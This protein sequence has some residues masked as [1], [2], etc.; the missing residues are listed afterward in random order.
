M[1][2]ELQVIGEIRFA[3]TVGTNTYVVYLV[4]TVGSEDPLSIPEVPIDR[5]LDALHSYLDDKLQS[6]GKT[7]LTQL[8]E[9][10]ARS[11]EQSNTESKTAE[12]L[13]R[14]LECHALEI[15]Q[16]EA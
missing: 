1:N 16:R 7:A 3:I 13:G 15:E 14:F 2:V 11:R 8:C 5:M 12:M 9:A 4:N 6:E 10:A